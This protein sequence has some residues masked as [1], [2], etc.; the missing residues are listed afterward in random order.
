MR[1]EITVNIDKMNEI[2]DVNLT[3]FNPS[4]SDVVESMSEDDFQE[5]DDLVQV[6][7]CRKA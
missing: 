2:T 3:G 5:I 7:I 6:E 4:V 1:L